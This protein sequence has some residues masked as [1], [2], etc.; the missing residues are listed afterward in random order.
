MVYYDLDPFGN[1]RGD[2][3]SAVIATVIANA[4]RGKGRAYKVK[5]FMPEFDK[6]QK[7]QT[8]DDMWNVVKMFAKAHNKVQ[9]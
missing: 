2:L 1:E 6:E 3:Q 9:R 8:H 5:D 7:K 4:W